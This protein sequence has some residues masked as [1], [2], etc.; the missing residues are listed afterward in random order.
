MSDRL[1]A[2]EVDPL[3]PALPK[4]LERAWDWIGARQRPI[5]SAAIGFN[6]IVLVSMIGLHAAP[7]VFGETI[8]LKTIPVDPRD[9]FRGDYV[10]LSYEIS[11]VPPEGIAGLPTGGYWWSRRT[12]DR[13][14]LLEGRTVYVTLELDADGRHWHGVKASTERPASGKF[15]RGQFSPGAWQQPLQF[16]I[17]AFYVQEGAGLQLERMRNEKQLSVEVALA[18]WGQAKLKRLVEE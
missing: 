13:D 15:I 2:T 1:F 18:P 10:V 9:M 6:A 5:L 4:W 17:E 3:A 12:W 11:R 8:L 14:S 16:G 7:Y